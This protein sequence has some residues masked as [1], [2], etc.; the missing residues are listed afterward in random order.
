MFI[1]CAKESIH[2]LMIQAML[3]NRILNPFLLLFCN[4]VFFVFVKK[5]LS[6][7]GTIN[8]TFSLCFT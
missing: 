2:T 8:P 7:Y 3:L 1:D 4:T 5:Q 6:N